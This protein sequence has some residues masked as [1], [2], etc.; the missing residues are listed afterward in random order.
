MRS[1]TS[2]GPGRNAGRPA[3]EANLI[4]NIPPPRSLAASALQSNPEGAMS[5]SL[6]NRKGEKGDIESLW[7]IYNTLS[8]HIPVHQATARTAIPDASSAEPAGNPNRI[9]MTDFIHN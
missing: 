6:V 7:S 1:A 5:M 3:S 4:G 9:K 8:I 2:I